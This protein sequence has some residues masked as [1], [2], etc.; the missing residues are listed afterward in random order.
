MRPEPQTEGASSKTSDD[1]HARFVDTAPKRVHEV[2]RFNEPSREPPKGDVGAEQGGAFGRFKDL[3]EVVH[4][5][6]RPLPT[7]TGN[8]TYIEDSSKGGS[9]WEDLLSLG[10]EDAKTVKDFVKT[11]ALR[12]PIDDKTMLM[13]RIIQMVAKLPDKSKIREKGTHKFLGILW[14]SLPH[15][16][17]SYVGD[18]YAYRSADGSYNNPTLPRLGAA[19]TEYART[20]EA[21]KMRPASMPDP[22]LIFDSIFAR[23]TFKPHPNNVSSIFFTWASLIIHDVFQTGYPDQSIN[24]TSSYLDLSTLYGDNQDEQN[25]IRTFEDGK[26]KPDCFSEPRLHILPAAS[27]VIL[28]ML[29]RFHNYVAE[30]L[31]IINENGRFTKPK[32]E[33]IDPVE[34]RLA[35]AKYDNDL[36]QTARL[37]TCGMYIN[38]TLYDYLRTIINLNRDN[39]T[40]NLDPR[41]HDDQDEIPTAQGNQC[42]V[43]FNLAY[44]WHSTIG[45]QDEAWTEKTYREIVGKPGQ[46]A[47]LQDLMDGMRKFNARMDK[48]PSKRT[49][50]GLQRQGNGT[51]RDVDLVD[52]LTRAIEEVSGS[53]GPNNVAKVLRSVEILGIQQARKWNIGSL[54]EFRKFFDL[55]PY[56]SFEEIN[57]DPYVADQLRHLY[58]HPDYVELYPGIVAEEPKEPM[59]PGVGIAPGYTV[60]R[61]VLSD[62]VTLVRGDRFYTKEFNARN[63]TNWGFSEAKYNLEINQGCSFYRLALR[64]FPKWFKYDSIY[65]HYP[66]TI[67]SENRVIMKALGREEDFSWDRPSYIPQRISVFDYANVRH[68]L[69]DASNFRVMWG[70]ATAYVFGSKGW[71][72]MLS[73]DAPT[74]ANQRN[75]MSRALYRGQWHDAVKQFYLDITQQLLTEKS[76]RIGNVNQVDISRDVGNL[77]HVHF[78]SNVFSPPLKSREHPHG[79]ITAHE[80]FEAMAVIFTAIFFDA[81]PVKS[82]ELRH[83]AREAANKLGRLVELNV[84]AIKSSGLIATLLGNMPANRNALFEYGVHMVERLLQSGLDPE[85]VTWSQVLPTAVAMVPNQA[86]VFTQIIDYYLSDKGRKHLPDIKRFAKEDSPASD[87]VLLRYCMEAIRL[88]GIFGSYRKS[89]T[90]LTLDD[91]GGKVHIKAGDNVF[92][93]FIDANRDPDVFPKPEEVDLNRP[94][95][96]YI[97][98]GVGPHTCL[99]SEASK[100]AL[101]TMLRVV[102]RLDNLRRA[103][104]AQGELKKIPREH[105]F[106][107]YMREDQSSFYPFPMSWKLHYDGEIPG[108]EQPVRGDFV[109]NVPGHWQN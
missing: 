100:V 64:A 104:G 69:Q 48:D 78:A 80:M 94:M 99:G 74:H 68:I 97:H 7:E 29:N 95:E 22:G 105:G 101:T 89:Q 43:E 40:W 9:L 61:A 67:P 23:E 47:T 2:Q 85:Q 37:I 103:P 60:S 86:Q 3:S 25:M 88:N 76:C 10:I 11:E 36:F 18:K 90:N 42:S 12:R 53:F 35:W 106:Y 20:T 54:N 4:K 45:R 75:I 38:I 41:T 63:L 62:A 50:A 39:S 26:I 107:T 49:F 57:P 24:K 91:K 8:G 65:P 34:A 27:G 77:A 82:F 108:K 55:K 56:E 28:I 73:G 16:P 83:K 52:I 6:T 81:E 33:I 44:R 1:S 31:A 14:N 93:S 98:Y 59:V 58:E 87:E 70:E 15:P 102:G 71:D 5:A 96:S 66:M 46:E 109:C 30:Q 51:F 21:S 79:I 92:V 19:N 84:K 13:E 72:F 17:L 32:A